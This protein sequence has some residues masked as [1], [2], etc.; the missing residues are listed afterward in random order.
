M[1]ELFIILG[2]RSWSCS[3]R[4]AGGLHLQGSPFSD[5]TDGGPH[6]LHVAG[7]LVSPGGDG[8]NFDQEII[9]FDLQAGTFIAWEPQSVTDCSVLSLL[10]AQT[11]TSLGPSRSEESAVRIWTGTR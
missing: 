9:I 10:Q 8:E 7:L 1:F 2:S 5:R 6:P 3:P 11:A 4:Q